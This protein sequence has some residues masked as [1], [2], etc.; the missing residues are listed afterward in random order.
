MVVVYG[1]QMTSSIWFFGLEKCFSNLFVETMIMK[2]HF[3]ITID[4][5][6]DRSKFSEV[7]C[8]IIIHLGILSLVPISFAI[9]AECIVHLHQFTS[10]LFRTMPTMIMF[11]WRLKILVCLLMFHE[12]EKKKK[13]FQLYLSTKKKKKKTRRKVSVS[14][15]LLIC[16][17]LFLVTLFQW[18]SRINVV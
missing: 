17:P 11:R 14:H 13:T 8:F 12:L 6:V 10:K 5:V 15:G 3:C 7:V 18:D 2:E 1:L 4:V 16:S 9:Y